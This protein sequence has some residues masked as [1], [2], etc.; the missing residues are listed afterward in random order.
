MLFHEGLWEKQQ[1]N[2]IIPKFP[3]SNYVHSLIHT[4]C[5]GCWGD[6]AASDNLNMAVPNNPLA[7]NFVTVSIAFIHSATQG[8]F[9]MKN[10]I[11]RPVALHTLLQLSSVWPLINAIRTVVTC[12]DAEA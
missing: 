1:K 11:H 7:L 3:A 12:P 4:Y 8:V 6:H 10:T 2:G 9:P 5:L